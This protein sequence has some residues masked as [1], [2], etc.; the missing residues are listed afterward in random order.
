MNIQQINNCFD[1]VLAPDLTVE[2]QYSGTSIEYA[3]YGKTKKHGR[4]D[5]FILILRYFVLKKRNLTHRGILREGV[6]KRIFYG[7]AFTS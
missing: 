1:L 4:C 2:S 7:Q 3:Y 6:K 5:V